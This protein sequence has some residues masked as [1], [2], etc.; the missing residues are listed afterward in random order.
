MRHKNNNIA[1]T[2]ASVKKDI[3]NIQ[4]AKDYFFSELLSVWGDEVNSLFFIWWNEKK[5]WSRSE[6]QLNNQYLLSNK[7]K[8]DFLEAVERLRQSEPIQYILG[9]VPFAGCTILTT[10]NVLIPRPE[11]EELVYLLKERLKNKNSPSVL[12]LCTGSGCIALALKKNIP[13]A[14]VTATDLSSEALDLA[15]K[16]AE[17]N[18]L[19]VHFILSD[20]LNGNPVQ[21]QFDLIVSNPPYIPPSESGKMHKNVLEFEPHLAL[22]APENDPLIFY[23]TIIEK[24]SP[25]LK[26]EAI[27]A[28]EINESMAEETMKLAEKSLFFGSVE[29]V[30]DMQGKPRMLLAVKKP[31]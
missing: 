20:V 28:F 10:K 11:T 12:D 5:C 25:F 15:V 8:G 1:H 7:E 26:K 2:F 9:S 3:E 29:C 17:L 23:R 21:G 6:I 13:D 19:S 16:S 24:Y 14:N 4:Q 27:L 22:F 18:Q 31:K 30:T